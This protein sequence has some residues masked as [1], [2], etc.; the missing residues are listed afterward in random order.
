MFPY[1]HKIP[2]NAK[3]E[4]TE[5]CR[6][7]GIK[8]GDLAICIQAESRFDPAA[9]N[10]GSSATGLIQFVEATANE[11]GTTT[12]SLRDMSFRQQLVFVEKYIKNKIVSTGIKNPDLY[13]LYLMIH[14]PKAA[15][16]PDDYVLYR[17]P[18]SAY[19]GNRLL[20]YNKDGNVTIKEIKQF[21]NK[22]VPIGYIQS[23]F[24]QPLFWVLV[25]L[26][27]GLTVVNYKKQILKFFKR[28]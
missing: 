23:V 1:Q 14:Y 17:N 22:S 15:G 26:G 16:K 21:L 19:N 6:R 10:W 13:D 5:M 7:L 4:Y 9:K 18:S 28:K 24:W 20:D 11:L 12:A 2:N 3:T 25:V 8:P 27:L